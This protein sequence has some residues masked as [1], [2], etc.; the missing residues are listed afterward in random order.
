M[1]TY[2]KVSRLVRQSHGYSAKSVAASR[3]RNRIYLAILIVKA[4]AILFLAV[5]HDG[6]T[7]GIE[8]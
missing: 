4:I 6:F 7:C 5:T 2:S 8:L 3:A 1:N